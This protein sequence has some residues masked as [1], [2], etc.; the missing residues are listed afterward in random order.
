MTRS[1]KKNIFRICVKPKCGEYAIGSSKYCVLHTPGIN[2]KTRQI[3][4]DINNQSV[5]WPIGYDKA[6][7][8]K[9]ET[10]GKA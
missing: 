7:Q 1:H 3:Y 9:Y 5:H 2:P 6:V 4:R 10:R 8:P